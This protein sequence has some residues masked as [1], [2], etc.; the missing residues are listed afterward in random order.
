MKLHWSITAILCLYICGYAFSAF[1]QDGESG[2]LTAAYE[3]NLPPFHFEE[4]GELQGF[5]IDILKEA[6][7]SQGKEIDFQ[8]MTETAAAAA[9]A[10]EEIDIIIG[11][12]YSERQAE[13]ME[14]SNTYYSTSVGLFVSDER[15]EIDSV[16]ELTD[17]TAAV[18][19]GS[20]ERDFLQNI[21]RIQFNE[22]STL[23]QAVELTV[24]GRADALAGEIT[25]VEELLED[26]GQRDNFFAADRYLVPMEYSFAVSSED[27]Q[28][29]RLLN[30]GLRNLQNDGTYQDIFQ[31]WFPEESGQ[32]E[33]LM[34]ALQILGL[35]FL[36]TAAVIIIGVRLNRRL[37]KE[38]N[39]KTESLN[40]V[41]LSLKKQVEA[42]KNSNEFQ[43]QILQSSPR[44]MITLN[45][46]GTIT[47]YS[48]K[49]AFMLNE[50]ENKVGKNYLEEKLLQYFLKGKLE[51]VLLHGKQFLGEEGEWVREDGIHLRLRAYIYP[52][53]NF[54]QHV[55]GVMFTFEDISEE[56][57]VRHKAFENEKNQALSRV[58][59]GIA[60]EIRNPL[61]S[62]KTFVELIPQKFDSPKFREKISAL[63]PQ[64]IERLNELIEGLMDYSKSRP[65]KKEEV[66]TSNLLESTHLLFDRTAANKG[67]EI[68]TF[69]EK[70]LFISTD[71][72]QLKQAVINLIINAVDALQEVEGEKWVSLKNY[73]ADG[74]VYVEIQDNGPGMS[75]R[76]QK[77]AFEPFYTTKADGTGLGL[78][79]AKQHV[80]E[81]NGLFDVESSPGKGTLIRL[82]FPG[83]MPGEEELNE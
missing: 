57:Q 53:Y 68:R 63:V 27:Y 34:L 78:A 14:F 75:E 55:I 40:N 2:T 38:V 65:A 28:T 31:E 44:G 71:R 48:P 51:D 24:L 52:L 11:M 73:K 9:L 54:E 1:A 8:P 49:A 60:H 76:V 62:I 6:V 41:N 39:R 61:T 35:A 23:E 83:Y 3:P 69:I 10:A 15:E 26:R 64:E 20:L 47:S 29:L 45:E 82:S 46:E 43:K 74:R 32:R 16:I 25:A 19:A 17:R 66:D 22:T 5:A 37:Q 59:A 7:S 30:N 4:D 81:N 70:E 79:I 77:Q 21:R 12:S 58:V 13:T 72:Q 80:E 67:V 50:E 36:V 56:V 18:K 33:N 42:T